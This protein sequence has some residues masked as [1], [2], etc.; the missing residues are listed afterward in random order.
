M[1]QTPTAISYRLPIYVKCWFSQHLVLIGYSRQS[2]GLSIWSGLM[3][4]LWLWSKQFVCLFQ[5]SRHGGGQI[6]SLMYITP[7]QRLITVTSV[8]VW[9]RK[10]LNRRYNGRFFTWID[11]HT[12]KWW[13]IYSEKRI[14]FCH[15]ES[16]LIFH[17]N[18]I[19]ATTVFETDYD[20][21]HTQI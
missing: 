4:M 14:P 10:W 8:K 9:L 1:L 19:P 6:S 13:T 17:H 20:T 3:E 21:L 5:Q 7:Q 16:F 12:I 18:I 15:Y 2:C 11:T